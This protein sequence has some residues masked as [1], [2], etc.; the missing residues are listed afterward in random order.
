MG[1]NENK[2]VITMKK[3]TMKIFAGAAI[4]GTAV[5]G[6]LGIRKLLGR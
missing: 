5:L 6:G 2:E 3:V 1:T 4:I